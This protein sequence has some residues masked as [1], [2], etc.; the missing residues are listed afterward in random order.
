MKYNFSTEFLTLCTLLGKQVLLDE[1]SNIIID[2]KKTK[3]EM[4]KSRMLRRRDSLI[5]NTR[6]D[7]DNNDLSESVSSEEEA[8]VICA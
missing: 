3:R 7:F 4:H 5:R 1:E 2:D 6:N 8:E